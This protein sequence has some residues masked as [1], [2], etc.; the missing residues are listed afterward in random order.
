MREVQQEKKALGFLSPSSDQKMTA[1]AL[2]W[3]E[4]SKK[5]IIW[6]SKNGVT[7]RFTRGLA[8]GRWKGRPR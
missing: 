6:H 5:Q 3:K 7:F 4:T 2:G 1:N 8:Q